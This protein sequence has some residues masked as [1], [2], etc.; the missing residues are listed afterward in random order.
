[1]WHFPQS[2]LCA[3]C[4]LLALL[5]ARGAWRA[6][7]EQRWW[8]GG[9]YVL[10]ACVS[11]GAALLIFRPGR[12]EFQKWL[13]ALAMPTG[14]V[15][16]A[17]LVMAWLL[18]RHQRRWTAAA[19]LLLWIVLTLAGNNWVSR[20]LIA[21]L[22]R[23][24]RQ[25]DPLQTAQQEPLDAVVALGG[26]S[27]RT[28]AGQA[29]VTGAGDRLVLAAR[30]YHSGGTQQLVC[31]GQA[32]PDLLGP[33]RHPAEEYAEIWR[34]LGVPDDAILKLPGSTTREEFVALAR[35]AEDADW[36]RIGVVTSAFHMRRAERLARAV[37]LEIVPLPANFLGRIPEP[38][39]IIVVPGARFLEET[40]VAAKEM[41]ARLAGR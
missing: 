30:L 4:L 22:E 33:G 16:L 27:S 39:L 2:T 5:L 40:S 18:F 32:N 12:L 20:S 36:Q 31:S 3:A 28:P 7:R 29:Q 8:A 24:Y 34:G 38:E 10:V 14:I 15:W 35:Q 9:G 21:H 19:L 23:D 41:L 26:G 6:W 13:V 25:L 1:M 37:G 17:L 11:A